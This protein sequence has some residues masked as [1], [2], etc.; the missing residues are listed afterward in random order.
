M[1]ASAST[2]SAA[3]QPDFIIASEVMWG[4][5]EWTVQDEAGMGHPI[6][7]VYVLKV[8][9]N[10][11]KRLFSYTLATSLSSFYLLEVV[12]QVR[13]SIL[14]TAKKLRPTCTE[15]SGDTHCVWTQWCAVWGH[16]AWERAGARAVMGGCE[17]WVQLLAASSWRGMEKGAQVFLSPAS[18]HAAFHSPCSRHSWFVC[19]CC[20]AFCSRLMSWA[21]LLCL[22]VQNW[23]ISQRF[24][25]FHP[26]RNR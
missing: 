10:R 13:S 23:R 1:H 15:N 19:S 6:A 5:T 26:Y 17:H 14:K 11:I 12:L 16:S 25:L 22:H 3:E 9:I 18:L 2:L 24:V 7:T 8:Q 4:S 21:S 20:S